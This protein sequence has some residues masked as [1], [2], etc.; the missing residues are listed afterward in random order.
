MANIAVRNL[1]ILDAKIREQCLINIAGFV[2]PDGDLINHLERT[3]LTDLALDLLRLIRPNEV[4]GE[5]LLDGFHAGTNRIVVRRRAVHPQQVLKDIDGD[6]RAF[7]DQ[8]GQILAHH[9]TGEALREQLVEV[10]IERRT[11]VFFHCLIHAA[12]S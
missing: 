3:A 9:T 8:L 11:G 12:E 2:E 10:R 4:F 5:D 6:V 1:G 7:L